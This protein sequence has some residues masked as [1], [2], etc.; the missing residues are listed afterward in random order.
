LFSVYNLSVC[1]VCIVLR[2]QSVWL[3]FLHALLS[4]HKITKDKE[5]KKKRALSEEETASTSNTSKKKQLNK[6]LCTIQF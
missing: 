2:C 3:F 6:D 1:N 5:I 4:G